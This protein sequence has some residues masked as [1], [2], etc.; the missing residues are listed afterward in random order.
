MKKLF[1]LILLISLVGCERKVS[2]P[3]FYEIYVAYDIFYIEKH[4]DYRGWY[5]IHSEKF[6][7]LVQGC[8]TDQA[9]KFLHDNSYREVNDKYNYNYSSIK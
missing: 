1:I 8:T 9:L 3:T 6:G 7:E 4:P 2:E 5:S